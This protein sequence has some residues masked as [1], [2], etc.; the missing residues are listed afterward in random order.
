[1]ST[2]VGLSPRIPGLRIKEA[3][4]RYIRNIKDYEVLAPRR[5]NQHAISYPILFNTSTNTTHA[6]AESAVYRTIPRKFIMVSHSTV[7]TTTYNCGLTMT[8]YHQG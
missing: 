7:R 2:S 8:S 3:E 5:L 6:D 4:R 1:V